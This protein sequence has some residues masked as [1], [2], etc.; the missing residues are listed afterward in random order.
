MINYEVYTKIRL[1]YQEQ[2]L[3]FMQIA[4][5]LAIDP[6]TVAK[7]ARA[8]SYRL[9]TPDIG[10]KMR[11]FDEPIFRRTRLQDIERCWHVLKYC[12]YA[13]LRAPLLWLAC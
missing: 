5:E 6:E 8:E 4:R 10:S 11:N 7:Y 9:R 12:C 1:Y 3:S 13:G 2:G